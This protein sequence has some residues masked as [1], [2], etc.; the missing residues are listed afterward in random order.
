MK[1][2]E[3]ANRLK[4]AISGYQE[5]IPK[6][7]DRITELRKAQAELDEK[8]LKMEILE[9]KGWQEAKKAANENRNKI[10]ELKAEIEKAEKAIEILEQ[11]FKSLRASIMKEFK[12]KFYKECAEDLQEYAKRL[13]AAAEYEQGLIERRQEVEREIRTTLSNGRSGFGP[14]DLPASVLPAFSPFLTAGPFSP[15][16]MSLYRHFMKTCEEQGINVD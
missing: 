13:K 9:E 3:D 1:N 8:A 7:N 14:Y 6:L 16:N 10:P 2:I 12:E 15:E 4:G 5:K 11:R